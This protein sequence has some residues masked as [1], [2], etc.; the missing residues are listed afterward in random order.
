MKVE[1]HGAK[2]EL[3]VENGTSSL[4]V[5]GEKIPLSRDIAVKLVFGENKPGLAKAEPRV[6]PRG[7]QTAASRRKLSESLKKYHAK[8]RR[9]NKAVKAAPPVAAKKSST[10][11]NGKSQ[12]L[13]PN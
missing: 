3:S 11:L 5:N 13:L 8:Q 9:K 10:H 2:V 12:L 7:C 1:L 6:V 4:K